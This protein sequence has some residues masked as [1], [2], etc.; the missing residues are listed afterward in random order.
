VQLIAVQDVT[1]PTFSRPADITIYLDGECN[2]NATVSETGDA[3]DASDN[4]GQELSAVFSDEVIQGPCVGS[5]EILR[6]WSLADDCGNVATAQVQL[7]TVFDIIAP[8]F[9]APADIEIYTDANCNYDASVEATGDVIDEWDN[10]ITPD[11]VFDDE[12]LEGSCVGSYI[13][14]RTWSLA[15]DCG[16]AAAD[17]TQIITVIDNTPPTFSKPA[18]IGI[19]TDGNC[20]YDA[21]IQATGDVTNEW[22]NCSQPE[23]AF[24]DEIIA[25]PCAGTFVITRTWT[26]VDDCGNAATTQTQIITVI[27]NTAPVALCQDITVY[28]DENGQAMITPDMIDNGSF[29]ICSDAVSLQ[30]DI[31]SF[32][33]DDLTSAGIPVSLSVLDHCGNESS[34]VAVV[35]VIDDLAPMLTCPEIVDPYSMDP[36]ECYATLSFEADVM[37][38][39]STNTVYSVDDVPIEFPHQ[40][41]PGT[42]TVNVYTS[43]SGGNFATCAFEIVVVDTELPMISCPAGTF[44]APMLFPTDEDV[45]T[46][47]NIGTGMDPLS[48]QDNCPDVVVHYTLLGVTTGNG[49]NTLDGQAFNTGFTTVR[50][51]VTDVAG[52][53]ATCS[54]MV[55]VIDDQSPTVVGC[56]GDIEAD[57]DPDYCGATVTWTEP[58]ALD[59]C[60]GP[61]TYQTRSHTP[62]SIFQVGTTQVSYTF[63]DSEGNQEECVFEII[64]TDVE[65]PVV[66]SCPVVRSIAGCEIDDIYGPA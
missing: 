31:V 46:Y 13:I 12:V 60:D 2:Y 24:S 51:T 20:N 59:N 66:V 56:P 22:D 42:T 52:N 17:Q 9:T 55:A 25:G 38:N 39:C 62:G 53:T 47:T 26:L 48:F 64:V 50:W 32:D 58:T 35:T 23:A 33:C 49:F 10:C 7:I 14:I 8:T 29:D 37:D 54:F 4:C 44:A 15:D 5:F 18:D 1:P 63:S 16:N 21:S 30:L 27:D 61:L 28:L 41:S 57:S 43:D 40:F 6:T 36:G 11:A 45:C 34:C 65:S 19:Y 3:T